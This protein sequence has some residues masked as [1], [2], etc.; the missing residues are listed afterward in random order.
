[1]LEGSCLCQKVQYQVNAEP[2]HVASC[3]C[4]MCQKHHGAAF[5][6]YLSVK[7]ENLK[8][9]EG[10]S[11]LKS[12]N[13]SSTIIRKFCGTCGSSI[14]WSGSPDE[15]DIVALTLA[16]ID[17]FYQPKVIQNI[18]YEDKACWLSLCQ[19]TGQSRLKKT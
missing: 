18:F 4:L 3:H 15:P 2:I 16:T 14:E 6:T 1:M 10:E 13:S 11:E 17:T 19:T 8:Y 12:Y 7:K 5:G 9:T